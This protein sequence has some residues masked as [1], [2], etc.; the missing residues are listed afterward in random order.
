MPLMVPMMAQKRTRVSKIRKKDEVR[1]IFLKVFTSL[2]DYVSSIDE[3]KQ[4]YI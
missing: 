3:V 1:L 2:A 4:K